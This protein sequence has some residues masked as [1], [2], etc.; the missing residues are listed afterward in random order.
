MLLAPSSHPSPGGATVFI[1][2]LSLPPVP[3]PSSRLP[4]HFPLQLQQSVA[5]ATTAGGA[6]APS[7]P[8]PLFSFPARQGGAGTKPEKGGVQGGDGETEV[9]PAPAVNLNCFFPSEAPSP[10]P[11]DAPNQPGGRGSC[12]QTGQARFNT[13]NKLIHSRAGNKGDSFTRR[14]MPGLGETPQPTTSPTCSLN[15]P[16]F[17]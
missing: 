6:G 11:G 15:F 1:S 5:R 8:S 7:T 9:G 16:F 2:I 12:G 14:G 13:Q 17:F 10:L 4:P 3:A